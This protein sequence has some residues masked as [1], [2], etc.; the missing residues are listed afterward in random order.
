MSDPVLV[1]RVGAVL[2]MTLNRPEVRNAVD[3]A[4]SRALADALDR[5]DGDDSLA[6]GIITGAGGSFCAGMDLRAFQRGEL[7]EVEGRGFAGL[8]EQ[9]PQTPLIA[10]V[11][12]Y[13]LAGGFELVLA[14]DL[15]VASSTAVFGLPEVRRGLIAG[16][17][18]LLRLPTRIPRSMAMEYAL[19]GAPMSAQDAHGWGL[20]NRL[21]APGETLAAAQDLAETIAGNGPLAVRSTKRVVAQGQTWPADEVWPRQRAI[22]D[23]VM[24]SEVAR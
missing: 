19:T 1:E 12:G 13:A 20:V 11:E 6:V 21:T 7:P 22:L 14:C 17:G 9:P 24:A 3:A 10:A 5:L 23:V 2:V 16:S 15:V 4:T 8:T 18:G